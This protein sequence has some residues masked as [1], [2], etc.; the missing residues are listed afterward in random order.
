VQLPSNHIPRGLVPLESI[1]DR[2]DVSLKGELSEDDTS[3][4]Q[5]NIGTESEPK[6]VKLSKSLTK[7]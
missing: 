7:E 6:F 3:T 1:F 2:N 5:C 4:I